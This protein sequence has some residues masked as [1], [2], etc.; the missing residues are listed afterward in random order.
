MKRAVIISLVAVAALVACKPDPAKSVKIV[1]KGVGT[2]APQAVLPP[3]SDDNCKLQPEA[4]PGASTF[5]AKG[6]CAFTQ[7]GNAK[8]RSL[9][10]DMYAAFLRK[11]SGEATVSVYINTEGYHG[12]GDYT[13]AQVSL[14][15]QDGKN[16]WYWSSDKVR[17]TV[18]EGVKSVVLPENTIEAEPPNTGA[19]V[20]SGKLI[21]D[22][23]TGPTITET[24]HAG[25]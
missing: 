16:F 4:K 10:D 2:P 5:V 9:T 8:C 20:I 22:K 3:W 23:W 18:N 24:P 19:I 13:G 21:C 14:T 17:I 25:G 1:D 6:K 15:Y 7:T 11:A 12:P